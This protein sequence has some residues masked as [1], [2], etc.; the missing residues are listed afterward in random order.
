MVLT[1]GGALELAD[2]FGLADWPTAPECIACM[3]EPKDTILLPCRHLCVCHACFDQLTARAPGEHDQCPVCRARFTSYLRFDPESGTGRTPT[4]R[5][6]PHE[7][8]VAAT[9]ETDGGIEMVAPPPPAGVA[10]A[11]IV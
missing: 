11:M 5:A 6:P 2:V 10:E 4:G 7:P 3:S 8:A 1:P 9:T